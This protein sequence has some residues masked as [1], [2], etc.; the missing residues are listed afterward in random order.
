[1]GNVKL[2]NLPTHFHRVDM[3]QT[4][5]LWAQRRKISVVVGVGTLARSIED[6]SDAVLAG[7]LVVVNVKEMTDFRREVSGVLAGNPVLGSIVLK[8]FSILQ[9]NP[10]ELAAGMPSGAFRRSIGIPVVA[11]QVNPIFEN[12]FPCGKNPAND[13]GI[14][15][16]GQ[17]GVVEKP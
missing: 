13:F 4:D 5:G 2:T 11:W 6:D 10:F 16:G 9:A 17:L 8:R 3:E 7:K 15:V 12:R 14:E 1:L